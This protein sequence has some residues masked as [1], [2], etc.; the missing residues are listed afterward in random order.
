MLP[1]QLIFRDHGQILKAVR[2]TLS[3]C[4]ALLPQPGEVRP[5]FATDTNRDRQ[6]LLNFS[7]C[8]SAPIMLLATS[9]RRVRGCIIFDKAHRGHVATKP[10]S[11]V[12]AL[13]AFLEASRSIPTQQT[14]GRGLCSER[15]G[16]VTSSYLASL[17]SQ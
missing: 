5:H 1:L 6:K 8:P 17:Q 14:E 10:K 12:R 16:P 3:A 13:T 11:T 2:D 7:G 9:R 15:Q 4:V